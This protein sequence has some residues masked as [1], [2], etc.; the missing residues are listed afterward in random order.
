[1]ILELIRLLLVAG[2]DVNTKG[3]WNRSPLHEA[4]L[5]RN[6]TLTR[7][8]I[9]VGADT[10]SRDSDD[11]TPLQLAVRRADREFIELLLK[12][13]AEEDGIMSNEWRYAF[14]KDSSFSVHLEEHKELG[15]S[16]TFCKDENICWSEHNHDSPPKSRSLR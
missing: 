12:N 5:S 11:L 14:Q 15:N 2:Y 13:L 1:M 6:I 9:L 7:E 10:N 3:F 16:I 8:V 4:I